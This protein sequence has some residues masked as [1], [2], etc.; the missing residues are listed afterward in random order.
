MLISWALVTAAKTLGMRIR[1]RRRALF[2]TQAELAK[3]CVVHQSAVSQ[4]ERDESVPSLRLRPV[5]A[6]ALHVFPHEFFDDIE[7]TEVAS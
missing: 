3:I 7:A 1:D 6:G 4:W 5:L 2:L